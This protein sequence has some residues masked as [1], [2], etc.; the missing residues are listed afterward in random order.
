MLNNEIRKRIVA[1]N[2]Y[3]SLL[4][5]NPQYRMQG[6]SLKDRKVVVGIIKGDTRKYK[7]TDHL[8]FKYFDTWEEAY[9]QLS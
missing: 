2:K 6:Y 1:E 7:E 5:S 8:N 3:Y 9:I 4:E